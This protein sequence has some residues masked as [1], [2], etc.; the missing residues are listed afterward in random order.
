MVFLLK[1]IGLVSLGTLWLATIFLCKFTVNVA[2]ES[3]W[4]SAEAGSPGGDSVVRKPYEH[5]HVFNMLAIPLLLPWG[6][7]FVYVLQSLVSIE[8]GCLSLSA[9]AMQ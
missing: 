8:R 1:T 3:L 5:P 6:F 4:Q 2:S 9:P 7:V